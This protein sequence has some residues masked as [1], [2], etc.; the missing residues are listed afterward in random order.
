LCKSYTAENAPACVCHVLCSMRLAMG[1]VEGFVLCLRA[2]KHNT[3]PS[4]STC[5]NGAALFPAVLCW[6]GRTL[7]LSTPFQ[8]VVN[9][10]CKS[11]YYH[12]QFYLRI[13]LPVAVLKYCISH[14]LWRV[15]VGVL[16][17]GHQNSHQYTI[18]VIHMKEMYTW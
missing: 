11:I 17:W 14:I 3:N 2:R 18:S 8:I 5:F 6:C 4:N 15:M 1:Y 7:K 10:I 13:W 16:F 9:L 12:C